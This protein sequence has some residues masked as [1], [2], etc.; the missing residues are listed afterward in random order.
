M[1]RIVITGASAG[2]GVALARNYADHG[3][4][5]GLIARRR[6]PLADFASGRN[7]PVATYVADVRDSSALQTAATD[8]L[9]R[10]GAPDIVIANA[11]VSVGTLTEYAE[12]VAAFE[13]VIDINVL[14]I[15]R[16]FQPF[17]AAM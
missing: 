13:Q 6:A 3:A 9:R 15:V 8:F 5:L 2:I 12:D 14:G 11:G 10:F 7:T 17:I 4:T 1:Q 16:T